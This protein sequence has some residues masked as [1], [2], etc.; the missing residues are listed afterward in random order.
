MQ[1]PYKVGQQVK[2]TGGHKL[3]TIREV[4]Q[5]FIYV[6]KYCNPMHYLDVHGIGEKPSKVDK[7]GDTAYQLAIKKFKVGGP[8]VYIIIGEIEMV[9]DE[10]QGNGTVVARIKQDSEKKR[11]VPFI[12]SG[13]WTWGEVG[14]GYWLR[15]YRGPVDPYFD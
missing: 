6:D 13:E 2:R 7:T 10:I 5:E 8:A 9:V 14:T 4:H 12:F 1:N 15:E 3:L 11:F